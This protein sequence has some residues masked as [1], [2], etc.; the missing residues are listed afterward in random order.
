MCR[1]MK[2]LL[3]STALL[4]AATGV[5]LATGPAPAA[6]SALAAIPAD[7]HART[8]AAMKP[9]KRARPAIAVIG[10]N[11]GTETTD[12]LIPYGVLAEAELG[13]VLA[14]APEAGPIKLL[15]ALAVEAQASFAGF[16]ARYPDGADYVVV[17]AMHPRDD[18]RV[19]AWLK[20]QK[21]KGAIV[22]G[23]CSGVRTLSAAG[24]LAG[25]RATSYWYDA[26]DM[27]EANPTTRWVRD[28]RYVADG[29]IVT[30]TGISASLPVSLAL[31]E[32]IA[33][34]ERAAEV[35]RRFGAGSWDA[36][37]DSRPF[38]LGRRM[39][40]TALSNKA[41]LWRAETHGLPVREGVDEVALGFTADAWSRTF[42]SKAAT[43]AARP[44][45]VTMRRGLKLIPDRV[46]GDGLTMQP[47]PPA[48]EPAKALPATLDAIAARYGRDTATFVSIQLEHPWRTDMGQGE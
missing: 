26:E 16:D 47:E 29:G 41:A 11:A 42:R 36:R 7:E 1:K 8:V 14:V 38:A 10:H 3:G 48:R 39:I 4:A 22:V 45:P 30:T 23:V 44:G 18:P 35:A 6:P 25:R 37:H 24:L 34:R 2:L 43:V 9:P 21:A 46:G 15:P 32:A 27:E 40:W 19:I 28:R 12:F 31:V 33:G 5:T 13:D 17:A 20:K